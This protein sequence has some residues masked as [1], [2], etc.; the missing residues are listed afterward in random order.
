MIY[1][2]KEA[3]DYG[4]RAQIEGEYNELARPLC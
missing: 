4:T 1:P 3:K 2:R